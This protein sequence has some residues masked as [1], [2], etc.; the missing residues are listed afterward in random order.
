MHPATS[1]LPR[2]WS[3]TDNIYN[4]DNYLIRDD[5]HVL[6]SVRTDSYTGDTM[7]GSAPYYD[8]PIAWCSTYYGA[9][10]YGCAEISKGP[11]RC[12]ETVLATI[13]NSCSTLV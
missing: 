10:P 4:Y 7:R 8:H 13:A 5:A 1:F 3:F 12:L 11:L 9:E 2:R 6:A